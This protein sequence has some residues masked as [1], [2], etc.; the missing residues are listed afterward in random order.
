M[1][2]LGGTHPPYRSRSKR[3][4]APLRVTVTW[5]RKRGHPAGAKTRINR[6]RRVLRPRRPLNRAS[7]DAEAITD[8]GRQRAKKAVFRK[9]GVSDECAD[10]PVASLCA[11]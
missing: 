9:K 5:P 4:T 8:S 10:A 3:L 2:P 6:A 11:S 1:V 7:V